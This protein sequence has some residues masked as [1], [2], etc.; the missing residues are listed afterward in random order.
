MTGLGNRSRFPMF[1]VVI[2]NVPG[3]Q[4]RRYLGGAEVLSIQ[5]ISFV[6]QGQ[7]PNITLFTY[8]DE[9]SFVYTACLDSLPRVQALVGHTRDALEELE[10]V[11]GTS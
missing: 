6:L 4:E 8:A 5:P 11:A 1:N 2:S 10:R 9:I 7:A 3:P